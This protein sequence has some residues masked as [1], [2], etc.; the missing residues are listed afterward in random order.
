[1]S[2]ANLRLT[3][4]NNIR[5]EIRTV[6]KCVEINEDTLSKLLY[7]HINEDE[8]VKFQIDKLGT[9]N[10]KYAEQIDRLEQRVVDIAAGKL[11]DDLQK[12]TTSVENDVN[13]KRNCTLN[14]KS[15]LKEKG[16]H[17]AVISKQFYIANR[18][19]DRTS[20]YMNK[21]MNR[22]Y[23]Y[24]LKVMRTVP[25]FI[26]RNLKKMPNNKGYLWRGVSLFGKLPYRNNC[27]LVLFENKR[28]GILYIHE[29][30]AS[31]YNIYCKKHRDK[32]KLVSSK[33]RKQF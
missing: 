19:N 6:K 33:P 8:Y 18:K 29:W 2:D 3:Y 25:E 31:R 12:E 9:E 22:S 1:M 5:T 26:T 30:T 16:E 21:N 32:K 27:P 28:G 4:A 11:D 17:Q 24:Y 23:R 7:D 10:E 20:K 14:K 15:E 13:A